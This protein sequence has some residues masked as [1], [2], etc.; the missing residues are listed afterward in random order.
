MQS[1]GGTENLVFHIINFI[2]NE[3]EKYWIIYW[4]F[5][6][7]Q[8]G[9]IWRL[10]PEYALGNNP[11]TQGGFSMKAAILKEKVFL[12]LRMYLCR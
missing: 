4:L 10:Q 6:L 8:R 5:Q 9:L 2:C 11:N 1:S 12:P 3:P 7:R